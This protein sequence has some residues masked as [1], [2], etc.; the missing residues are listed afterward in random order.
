ML[1]C[2][3]GCPEGFALGCLVYLKI[4]NVTIYLCNKNQNTI[5]VIVAAFIIRLTVIS[6]RK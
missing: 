2:P 3:V 6:A 5:K 1:G 4:K